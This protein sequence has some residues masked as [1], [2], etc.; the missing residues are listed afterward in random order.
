MGRRRRRVRA[1]VALTAGALP[2]ALGAGTASADEFYSQSFFREHTFTRDDGTQVTCNFSGGSNLSRETGRDTYFADA[3]TTAFGEDPACGVT[4]VEVVATY[5][6]ASGRQKTTGANSI[7]GDVKWFTD[8]VSTG[9]DVV[10]RVFFF[11]CQ[12]NCEVSA[13]TSPK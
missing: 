8:D 9:L 10:H 1:A 11:D 2:F 12:A 5:R 3:L 13:T 6:D 7:E 4:F